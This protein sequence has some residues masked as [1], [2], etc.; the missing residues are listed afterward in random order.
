[1]GGARSFHDSW[2]LFWVVHACSN[3]GFKAGLQ[4]TLGG[5]FVTC[6]ELGLCCLKIARATLMSRVGL[7]RSGLNCGSRGLKCKNVLV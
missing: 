2:A 5:S 7:I 3:V 4:G 6:R 1:M